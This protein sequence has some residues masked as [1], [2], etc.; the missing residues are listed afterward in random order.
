MS[1]FVDFFSGQNAAKKFYQ[2]LAEFLLNL[3]SLKLIFMHL[4]AD[5]ACGTL[6]QEID[7]GSCV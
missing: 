4:A 3:F 2:Q 7:K 6:G 5:L 1:S